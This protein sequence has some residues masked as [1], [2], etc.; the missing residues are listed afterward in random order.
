MII[1]VAGT[2]SFNFCVARSRNSN[3]PDHEIE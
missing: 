2:T 3:W 1:S